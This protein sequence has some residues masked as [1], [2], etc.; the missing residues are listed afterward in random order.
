MAV[1]VAV[2]RVLQDTRVPSC[3]PALLLLLCCC[4]C[5]LPTLFF[6]TKGSFWMSHVY[7]SFFLLF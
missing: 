5:C 7:C 2:L 1:R 3:L 6:E 4:R